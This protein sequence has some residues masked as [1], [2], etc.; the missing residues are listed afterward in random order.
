[1][2]PELDEIHDLSSL[3]VDNAAGGSYADSL[4]ISIL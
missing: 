3:A 2:N 1:M 4:R